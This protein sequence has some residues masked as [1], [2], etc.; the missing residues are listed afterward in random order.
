MFQKPKGDPSKPFKM[1]V[2]TLDFDTHKGKFAIGNVTQGSVKKGDSLL[3]L[4]ENIKRATF[5]VEAV[6]TS[7]GLKRIPAEKGETGDIIA[8]TGNDSIAIGQTL[9]DPIDPTGFPKMEVEEPT[10]KVLVGPNTSP[11][12]G[13]KVRTAPLPN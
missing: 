1:L 3:I 13:K 9:A 6:F 2:T 11:F 4:D 7:K 8:I 5:K 10:L 12:A